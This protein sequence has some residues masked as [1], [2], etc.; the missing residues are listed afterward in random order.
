MWNGDF[1]YNQS[2]KAATCNLN[3]GGEACVIGGIVALFGCDDETTE[4]LF[5]CEHVD[6]NPDPDLIYDFDLPNGLYAVNLFFANTYDG[7]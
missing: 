1:G 4:D 7:S 3:G 2:A 6:R 5:Q